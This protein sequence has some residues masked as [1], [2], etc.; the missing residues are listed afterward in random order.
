MSSSTTRIIF[1]LIVVFVVLGGAAGFYLPELMLSLGFVGGLYLNGLKLIALPLIISAI[2]IGLSSLGSARKVGRTSGTMLLYFGATT[3]VASFIGLIMAVLF[4]PGIG[5]SASATMPGY[6]AVSFSEMLHSLLPASLAGGIS[7]GRFIGVVIFAIF[8]ATVLGSLGSRSNKPVI[9]FFRVIHAASIKLVYMALYAA[10]VGLFCLV[11]AQV[12]ANRSGIGDLAGGLGTLTVAVAAGLLIQAVIVLPLLL[13]LLAQRSPLPYFTNMMPALATAFGSG[14][15]LATMP[16][17]YEGVVEKNGVDQRAGS[18]V[19]PLG[20][21]INVNGTALYVTLATIFVAQWFNVNLSLLEMIGIA[22]ASI[23]VSIVAAGVPGAS[24]MALAVIFGWF[25]FPAQAFAAIGALAAVSWLTERLCVTVN[26]WGDSIGAAI[27]SE[28]FEFKTVRRVA[29]GSVGP[30]RPYERTSRRTGAT[31]RP[32]QDR[33]DRKRGGPRE[34]FGA[35]RPR[36]ARTKKPEPSP[37][38]MSASG[39]EP[40]DL[41][42]HTTSDSDRNGKQPATRRPRPTKPRPPREHGPDGRFVPSQKRT[43]E[44]GS[45]RK[46]AREDIAGRKPRSRVRQEGTPPPAERTAATPQPPIAGSSFNLSS[47]PPLPSVKEK[48][49]VE[50][51]PIATPANTAQESAKPIEKPEDAAVERNATTA[52]VTLSREAIERDLA[53]VSKRLADLTRK[54]EE[55]VPSTPPDRANP[56]APE[57]VVSAVSTESETSRTKAGTGPEPELAASDNPSDAKPT[58]FGRQRTLRGKARSADG[59]ATEDNPKSD[60]SNQS[61]EFSTENLTFGRGKKKRTR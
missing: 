17:T 47:P 1:L 16:V 52:E 4:R 23:L 56:E 5:N 35:D 3:A 60:D 57:P 10:P 19:I 2:I 27:V 58:G 22:A 61:P 34:R 30:S 41:E 46:T 21:F 12:A 49:D 40:L 39:S 28:T 42:S 48:A 55:P 53:K 8:F 33:T 15:S 31:G 13:R 43:T 20:T 14:S 24:L 59:E 11:G 44:N 26:V 38:E 18:A 54:A 25:G 36:T 50:Q 45:G 32:W 6:G 29:T 9:D 37:F 51:S 7:E